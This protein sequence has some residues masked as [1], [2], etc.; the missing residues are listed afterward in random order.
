MQTRSEC[1]GKLAKSLFKPVQITCP[2]KAL[3]AQCENVGVA[4]NQESQNCWIPLEYDISSVV[5]WSWLSAT[6]P[7]HATKHVELSA[8]LHDRPAPRG[9]QPFHATDVAVT[10]MAM[11]KDMPSGGCRSVCREWCR[12]SMEKSPMKSLVVSRLPNHSSSLQRAVLH[13]VAACF[14]IFHWGFVV[15]KC[16]RGPDSINYE[17]SQVLHMPPYNSDKSAAMII[18]MMEPML[19]QVTEWTAWTLNPE[20]MQAQDV[21]YCDKG[22]SSLEKALAG[23]MTDCINGACIILYLSCSWSMMYLYVELTDMSTIFL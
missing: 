17:G 11:S 1:C 15:I 19:K 5:L 18:T 4:G 7:Q 10:P 9:P 6:C 14:N 23:P 22:A 8:Q 16:H 21:W 20:A 3:G 2:C 13:S 12:K